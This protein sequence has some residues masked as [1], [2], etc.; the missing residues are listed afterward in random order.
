MAMSNSTD[1]C[2]PGD[3]TNIINANTALFFSILSMVGSSWIIYAHF[4]SSKAQQRK[5]LRL[6]LCFLSMM[7]LLA[8][9]F[10][11][12]SP[13]IITSDSV[14]KN[15]A[16]C[17]LQAVV[18]T[19]ASMS[20]FLS[21]SLIGGYLYA[22]VTPGPHSNPLKDAFI[23]AMY[24]HPGSTF[25]MVCIFV[26]FILCLVVFVEGRFGYSSDFGEMW[27]WV[28]SPDSSSTYRTFLWRMVAG[29]GIELVC[30][31][32]ITCTY[33]PTV[34]RMR[35]MSFD[36]SSAVTRISF[37]P[38]A[39][40]ILRLPSFIRTLMD[41]FTSPDQCSEFLS[42]LQAIGDPSQGTINGLI[43]AGCFGRRKGKGGKKEVQEA[44]ESL[45]GSD[46]GPKDIEGG[47]ESSSGEEGGK[48]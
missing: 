28:S 1:I 41:L 5:T 7:D 39:F 45:L 15:D 13:F 17:S 43:Y 11:T 18:T 34:L 46:F 23:Q 12:L 44:H 16:L 19:F 3:S 38:G 14:V 21:T 20:S 30:F 4:K 48:P 47:T 24:T 25:F 8:S 29:K 22:A 36:D 6:L 40:I 33:I 31:I 37:V 42:I 9:S 2:I 35:K 26:P 10:Y 27:C 32:L